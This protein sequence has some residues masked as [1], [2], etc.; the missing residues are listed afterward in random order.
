[1]QVSLDRSS[2][3][4]VLVSIRLEKP[5]YEDQV[6]ARIRTYSKKIQLKGFRRGNV[7]DRVVQSMYGQ[8]ILAEEISQLLQK[9][10]SE[11]LSKANVKPLGTPV[12]VEEDLSDVASPHFKYKV[13]TAGEFVCDLSKNIRIVKHQVKEV[14][15][16]LLQ[17]HIKKLQRRHSTRKLLDRVTADSV[18]CGLLVCTSLAT[19]HLV[20]IVMAEA[21]P[22]AAS[23]LQDVEKGTQIAWN[24]GTWYKM[25]HAPCGISPKLYEQMQHASAALQLTV[26]EIYT[27]QP[28][29]LDQFFFDKVLGKGTVADQAS[30]HTCIEQRMLSQAQ[31][32]A[33]AYFNRQVKEVLIEDVNIAL[34]DDFLRH[35]LGQRLPDAS[36]KDL[37][38]HYRQ[39][40]HELRWELITARIIE[41]HQ[42]QIGQDEVVEEVYKRLQ[43]VSNAKADKLTH[44][45]MHQMAQRFSQDKRRPEYDQLVGE[46]KA[47]K[48]MDVIQKNIQVDV[49]TIDAAELEVVLATS[50][51][52][53]TSQG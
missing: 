32:A 21:L 50:S 11:Q 6:T 22:E 27:C 5:D 35:W 19:E 12:L 30:F 13:G 49:H 46:L 48:A 18:V 26:T 3:T 24:A 7:P 8:T 52:P 23:K 28:A 42:I 31:E 36:S 40:A 33:D 25:G 1:M 34:P 15:D 16:A 9:T 37:E 45:Q 39:Y 4:E 29:P 41:E 51:A 14:G 17:A 43:R 53:M 38:K 20:E 2:P 10:L 44:E 47:Q